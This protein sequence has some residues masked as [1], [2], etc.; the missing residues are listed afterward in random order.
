MRLIGSDYPSAMFAHVLTSDNI[1][2]VS[3]ESTVPHPASRRLS[4]IVALDAQLGHQREVGRP[5][6]LT[7]LVC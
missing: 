3:R 5:P 2:G 1:L 7:G 4:G 6:D